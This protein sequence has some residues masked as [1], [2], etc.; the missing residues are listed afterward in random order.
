MQARVHSGPNMPIPSRRATTR[1]V[2]KQGCPDSEEAVYADVGLRTRAGIANAPS[3]ANMAGTPIRGIEG[4]ADNDHEREIGGPDLN[5]LQHKKFRTEYDAQYWSKHG[6]CRTI[7]FSS[8]VKDYAD[9]CNIGTN[10][11]WIK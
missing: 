11:T 9:A 5:S 4:R 1:G 3:G 7:I 8:S 6:K 10:G 2:T